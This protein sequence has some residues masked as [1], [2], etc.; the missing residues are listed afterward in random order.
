MTLFAVF[1]AATF[2]VLAWRN[3]RFALALLFGLLP[4]YLLRFSVGPVPSTM[5]ELLTLTLF[6]I[7]IIRNSVAKTFH[8]SLFTS[9][10]KWRVVV[11]LLLAAAC[12]AASYAPDVFA[13]LGVL[14]AYY[15]EPMLVAVMLVSTFTERRDWER[16]G[17]ALVTSGVVVAVVAIVQHFTGVGIPAP[18]DVEGRATSVFDFPNG[19]GLFLAPII[20]GIFIIVPHVTSHRTRN[21]LAISALLMLGGIVASATEAAFVAIP[22]ALLLTLMLSKAKWST[23]IGTVGVA[24]LLAAIAIGLSGTVREKILLRDVSGQARVAMWH[25]TVSMLRDNP[26]LGAGLSGFPVAIAPYHDATFYEIFQYPHNVVLNIWVELGLLGL[27][28]TL[29]III[30]T[31]KTT[32]H[33]RDDP[34]T[35]A[36]FAALATMLIHGLVDV[37]F[38]KNDLAVMTAGLLA[39]LAVRDSRVRDIFKKKVAKHQ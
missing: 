36:A 16:A 27:V 19:V 20:T 29:L 6:A 28:A 21:V 32:W 33:H 37:P 10:S 13:A 17:I 4:T 7:W 26:I 11:L 30:L 23:K 2:G 31:I 35:L 12:F 18:W 3:F 25:E 34:Y 5:L 24:L 38:F 9:Y 1:I 8:F 15:V 22:A 14:K 39:F